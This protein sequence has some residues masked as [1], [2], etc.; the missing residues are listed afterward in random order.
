[1]VAGLRPISDFTTDKD[2]KRRLEYLSVVTQKLVE[3]LSVVTSAWEK[4]ILMDENDNPVI[5]DLAE[6]VANE[7]VPNPNNYMYVGFIDGDS[8]NCKAENLQWVEK[9]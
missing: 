8:K 3:D 5:K 9:L 6:L 2:A 4:V 1:M 7:F